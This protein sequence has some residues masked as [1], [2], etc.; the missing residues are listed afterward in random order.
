VTAPLQPPVD[1]RAV[2]ARCRVGPDTWRQLPAR[3]GAGA[4]YRELDDL[5]KS[6]RDDTPATVLA[7]LHTLRRLLVDLGLE[8]PPAAWAAGVWR[9]EPWPS[10]HLD[11]GLT[12]GVNVDERPPVASRQSAALVGAA[13]ARTREDQPQ[14]ADPGEHRR[15]TLSS[16]VTT[17]PHA[18]PLSRT[19]LR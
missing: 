11:A 10:D 12:Q 17:R 5:A 6:T 15:R 9:A 14:R 7:V 2:L 4:L 19:P 13:W 16:G 8:D 1:I 18:E 3:W